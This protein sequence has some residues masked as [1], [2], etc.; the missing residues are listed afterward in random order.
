MEALLQKIPNAVRAYMQQRL[1]PFLNR[2]TGGR[3]R[4]AAVTYTSFAMHVPIA[5]L[6][7][8]RHNIPAA[9]LLTVFGILDSLDGALARVQGT[10]S[11]RGML[12]DASTDRMKEVL[13]YSGVGYALAVS[14]HPATAA[15]AAAACGASVTVS[16]V[17]AKGEA[18]VAAAKKNIPHAVLN[19]MFFDGLLTFEIRMAV[20]VGGLLFNQLAFATVFIAVFAGATALGRLQRISKQLG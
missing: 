3:L 12:L 4:P 7:A 9:V 6:I 20:L 19:K 8:T 16:Y 15:F 18:V 14:A 2:L 1:A 5:L 11:E 13:L 17:K 10:A